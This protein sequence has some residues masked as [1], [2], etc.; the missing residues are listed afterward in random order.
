MKL[1]G[2]LATARDLSAPQI[3]QIEDWELVTKDSSL[4]VAIWV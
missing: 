4:A 3:E 1:K 2:P